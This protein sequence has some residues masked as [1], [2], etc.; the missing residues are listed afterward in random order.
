MCYSLSRIKFG[1]RYKGGSSL[2]LSRTEGKET[3]LIDWMVVATDSGRVQED[4]RGFPL[5]Y[6]RES[7]WIQYDLS[8]GLKRCIC[9]SPL[10]L[11]AFYQ[12]FQPLLW[13]MFWGFLDYT[14]ALWYPCWYENSLR[15]HMFE[16]TRWVL[17][18]YKWP[19]MIKTT[20]KFM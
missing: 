6:K 2:T 16:S 8:S 4:L 5:K 14:Q 19:K 10:W 15:N 20:K 17:Q 3:Q 1:A 18:F 7:L 11:L 13:K 9:L 12:Q